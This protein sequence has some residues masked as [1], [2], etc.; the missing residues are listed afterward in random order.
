LAQATSSGGLYISQRSGLPRHSTA[1]WVPDQPL[2]LDCEDKRLHYRYPTND[3]GRTLTFVGFQDPIPE[4]PAGT[5]LRIS[6][7]HWWHP[8]DRPDEE[9]RCFVQ[10]SGWFGETQSRSRGTSPQVQPPFSPPV[11]AKQSVAAAASLPRAHQV[12]KQTFGYSQFL[13]VQW[14]VISRVLNRQDTLAIMPTGGGKSLCYQLPAI[15]SDGLSRLSES[16][17]ALVLNAFESLGCE[18]LA[19]VREALH[20]AVRFLRLKSG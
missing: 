17:R 1:F 7:A 15:M 19:P 16:E 18:R 10:L 13:P 20:G 11:P 6:L 4:I 3:G 5:L 9:L 14:D 2:Q 8:K 12:L